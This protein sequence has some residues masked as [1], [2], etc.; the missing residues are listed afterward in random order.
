MGSER[1][2]HNWTTNTTDLQCIIL[3]IEEKTELC[4]ENMTNPQ[5]KRWITEPDPECS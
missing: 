4:K 2:G 5:E 3:S 1:V